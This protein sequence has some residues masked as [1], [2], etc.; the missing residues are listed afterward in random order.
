MGEAPRAGDE[1]VFLPLGGA[2]EIGMNL[3]L[4]GYGPPGRRRWIMIDCGVT[5]GD[6]TMPG[7]DLIMAD[8]GFI[9]ERQEDLLGLVLTHAHE[10]HIGAVP[11]LWP[12]L[13]CPVYATPFTARL[14][15]EKLKEE[16]LAGTVPLHVVP[17]GGT[18][19]LGPFAVELITITHSIPEPNALAIRTPLGTV[20]HTGDWKIDAAPLI[21]EVTDEPALRRLGDEGV[22]AMICDSTNVFSPGRAGSEAAVR[23]ELTALIAGLKRRVAVTAFASNVARLESVILAAEAVDRH[24]VLVGRAM[25][26]LIEAA[27]SA[28]YLQSLPPL[29]SEED[30]GWLPPEKVLYLCTGSQ[31]EP[32]AALSRI[33]AGTHPRVVLEPGDTV[34]FSSRIIPGNERAIAAVHNRLVSRGI[35]VLTERDHFV[36]VSGHPCRDDLADMYQWIR[37]RIAIPVHGETRHLIE[38]EK[39]AKA[40][41]V[42]ETVLATNGAM[43]RLAPGPAAI[44]ETVPS[45]RLIRD[46]LGLFSDQGGALKERRKL[47]FA[48]IITATLVIDPMGRL[49]T[50]PRVALMGVPGDAAVLG[51][52]LSTLAADVVAREEGRSWADD[53][54]LGEM[55]RRAL[56]KAALKATGV[57]PETRVEVIRLPG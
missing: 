47:S 36:H 25:K 53:A 37:P 22:L 29:L 10:D 28:G 52:E 45:G 7:V 6:D 54:F 34:I 38:H 23:A 2:G 16:G 55:T 24:V 21:G 4:L 35:E 3:N 27:Q 8:P 15:L 17:L 1:L 18:V 19:E 39:F 40:M 20:V 13:R 32:R 11:Y 49:A 33:A 48:G 41:Q 44:A 46:G 26:R 57:K 14:V 56:R 51:E 31:G 5:F 43:V 12:K 50:P 30:G 9:A 42:P